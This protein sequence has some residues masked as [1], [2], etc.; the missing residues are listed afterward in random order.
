VLRSPGGV[1]ACLRMSNA[2]TGSSRHSHL[3]IASFVMSLLPVLLVA[4]TQPPGADQTGY[5]GMMFMAGGADGA[6][7]T[8]GVGARDSGGNAW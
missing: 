5:A 2:R 8:R 6:L 1:L 3:G 7:R 4:S